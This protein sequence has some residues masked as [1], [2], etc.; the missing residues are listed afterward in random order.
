MPQSAPASPHG[1]PDH[2]SFG[3]ERL[4]YLNVAIGFRT[5]KCVRKGRRSD[6]LWPVNR[7]CSEAVHLSV[8]AS[9]RADRSK[10]VCASE[11]YYLLGDFNVNWPAANCDLFQKETKELWNNWC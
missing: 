4:L 3:R 9:R 7:H 6:F 11:Q 8:L 10:F 5:R 1:D 2:T